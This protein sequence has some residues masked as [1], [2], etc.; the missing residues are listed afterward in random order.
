MRQSPTEKAMA[1]RAKKL[2]VTSS[3]TAWV[4]RLN[5]AE[6]LR[7][8]ARAA[9]VPC[10][11]LGRTVPEIGFRDCD[12]L[13]RVAGFLAG[14]MRGADWCERAGGEVGELAELLAETP[15]DAEVDA[16]WGP[17]GWVEGPGAVAAATAS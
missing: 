4:A 17:R 2:P 6:R 15:L 5:G 12:W 9:A 7:L 16:D 3:E 10:C 8:E 13:D 11:N 14:A 1:K